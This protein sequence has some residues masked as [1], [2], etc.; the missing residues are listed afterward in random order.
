MQGI[1][2]VEL[3]FIIVKI[4]LIPHI[5]PCQHTMHAYVKKNHQKNPQ[6]TPNKKPQKTKPPPPPQK[7]NQ[8]PKPTKPNPWFSQI[9][10]VV[11]LLL[12]IKKRPS[13]CYQSLNQYVSHIKYNK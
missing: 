5:V 1:V 13:L 6:K 12:V 2:R 7:K 9:E 3:Q 4:N 10:Q 8:K 11:G